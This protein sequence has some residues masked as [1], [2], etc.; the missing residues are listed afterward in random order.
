M[1]LHFLISDTN[2]DLKF[3]DCE[4]PRDLNETLSEVIERG[5]KQSQKARV[6]MLG[7]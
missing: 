6:S 5:K 7:Y 4:T 3:V 2:D 1:L